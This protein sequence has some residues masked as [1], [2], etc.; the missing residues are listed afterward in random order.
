MGNNV[1]N[2]VSVGFSKTMAREYKV[3]DIRQM[4]RPL[5]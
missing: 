1:E 4:D 2:M 3:W 5:L